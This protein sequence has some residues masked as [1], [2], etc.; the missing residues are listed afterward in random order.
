MTL[1]KDSFSNALP[2]NASGSQPK[3]TKGMLHTL[4]LE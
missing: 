1:V 3:G 2:M 4:T